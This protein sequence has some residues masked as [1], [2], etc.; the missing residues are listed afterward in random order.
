MTLYF[1]AIISSKCLDFYVPSSLFICGLGVLDRNL[2][3][4][5]DKIGVS[6]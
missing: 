6:R 4:M 3:K 2:R 1:L 5:N